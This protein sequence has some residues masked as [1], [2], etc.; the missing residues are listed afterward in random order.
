MK[1]RSSR[2]FLKN[3]PLVRPFLPALRRSRH[4][5]AVARRNPDFLYERMRVRRLKD[6]LRDRRRGFVLGNGPSLRTQDLTRLNG[7]VVFVSNYFVKHAQY[8]QIAPPYYWV[9]DPVMAGELDKEWGQLMAQKTR[10]AVKFLTLAGK[11]RVRQSGLFDGHELYYLNATGPDI[12]EAGAA[13][14][15][16]SVEMGSADTNVVSPCLLLAHF[17]GLREV[18]LM[19]CDFDYGLDTKKT[20]TPEYFF[21]ALHLSHA[22]SYS[23]D[24]MKSQWMNHALTSAAIVGR[25]LEQ[26]GCKI[27]NA[28]AGGKLELFPR[29]RYEDLFE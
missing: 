10:G 23:Q 1:P 8:E 28:T 16:V 14:L 13:T 24:Y 5:C 18:Y 29:V 9:G 4:W 20:L 12:W 22:R 7:E 27:Y 2:T 25:L 19:G 21:G 3:L 15:D 6:S 17:M 11:Q 26:Q